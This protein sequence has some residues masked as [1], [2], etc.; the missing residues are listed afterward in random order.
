MNLFFHSR[1]NLNMPQPEK[2]E[3]VYRIVTPMFIGDADQKASGITAA[4]VKGALRFWWRALNWGRVRE[5]CSNDEDALKALHEEEAE[6]FG[7]SAYDN[8]QRRKAGKIGIGQSKVRLR[9]KQP[10]N[11]NPINDWPVAPPAGTASNYLGM[12]L[13][14]TRESVHR[15]ALKEGQSF[16][17]EMV[18]CHLLDLQK[19]SLLQALKMLGLA[20]GIGG[21][22][23]RAFGSIGIESLNGID[24]QCA[25]QEKYVELLKT[26]LSGVK[27]QTEYP[28]YTA[29][30]LG[31]K[32]AITTFASNR[33][34]RACH[35]KLGNLYKARRTAI[36]PTENRKVFGLPMPSINKR[37]ASPL[38]FHI[39]PLGQAGFTGLALFMP[40]DP[41]H[42]EKGL[43]AVDY[44]FIEKLLDQMKV[45]D[46]L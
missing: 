36:T 21:R 40:S 11:L 14:E 32:L 44:R 24:Y 19:Q 17:L 8:K 22:S 35:A 23:R 16:T 42:H 30:C 45:V 43:S 20:G 25:S 33:D 2:I 39:H 31:S 12:G 4:S 34:A 3:A 27:L 28:P 46:L 37:R 15:P 7:S 13:W 6:L 26:T 9:I 10:V 18:C 29:F 38:F 5:G 1:K 41:F